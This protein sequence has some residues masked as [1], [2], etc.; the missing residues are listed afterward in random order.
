MRPETIKLLEEN[1][2]SELLDFNLL[3]LSIILSNI[4]DCDVNKIE[5]NN[6]REIITNTINTG[7]NAS[8]GYKITQK[9]FLNNQLN[10]KLI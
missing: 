4:E 6:S 1:I 3:F 7:L 5:Q 8:Q 9:A 2:D 10:S